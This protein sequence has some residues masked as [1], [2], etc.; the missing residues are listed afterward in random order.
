M[1]GAPLRVCVCVCVCVC[2]VVP[3]PQTQCT[4]A[5]PAP[6]IA[7]ADGQVIVLGFVK[8]DM[9]VVNMATGQQVSK[10]QKA[11][12]ARARACV[13]MRVRMRVRVC[14]CLRYLSRI[15][16]HVTDAEDCVQWRPSSLGLDR[17][18]SEA[19]SLHHS[20][21]DSMA[22]VVTMLARGHSLSDSFF[23]C[24]SWSLCLFVSLSLSLSLTHSLSHSLIHST[25]H[26]PTHSPTHS[27]THPDFLTLLFHSH[28]PT[29]PLSFSRTR[30]TISLPALSAVACTCRAR[31]GQA[32]H[33]G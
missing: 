18:G 31:H 23:P 16:T 26:S 6:L 9:V 24:L 29:Q 12:R 27:L 2:V 5:L 7:A 28:P 4:N 25:T 14:V 13:R 11:V 21:A 20:L 32:G 15:L 10:G 30:G 1:S 22:A 33:R 8:T 3:L 19:G 17:H